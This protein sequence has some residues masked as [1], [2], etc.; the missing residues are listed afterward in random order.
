MPDGELMAAS[1]MEWTPSEVW[2]W[3][4]QESVRA[5]E[6]W[7]FEI[8]Y[9]S[10]VMLESPPGEDGSFDFA[11]FAVVDAL[12]LPGTPLRGRP[13]GSGTFATREEFLNQVGQAVRQV[14]GRG[15]RATQRE[16]ARMMAFGSVFGLGDPPR[17]L[18]HWTTEFGFLNWR[19]L[20]SNF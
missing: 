20:L 5:A 7:L 11:I 14:R 4:R 19:D 2:E 17:Q 10:A 8:P 3:L 1:P 15:D 9:T 18:R 6:M 13:F 12:A 16:V